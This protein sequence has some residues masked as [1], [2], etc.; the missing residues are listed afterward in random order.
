MTALRRHLASLGLA[1]A[2]CHLV[3]QILVPAA[4]CCQKLDSA[5][6]AATHDCCPAGSHAGGIC[7]M[8]GNRA[9]SA[10]QNDCQARPLVDL[11]DIFASLTSGGVLT[12]LVPLPVPAGAEAAP[13]ATQPVTALVFSVPPGPPPRA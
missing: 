1:V 9:R 11:H 6:K 10:S 12:A 7:P 8:H 13:V 5:P 4:L 2:S 3:I